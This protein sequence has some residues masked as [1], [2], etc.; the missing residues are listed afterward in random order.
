[1]MMSLM[2]RVEKRDVGG[3]VS[4]VKGRKFRIYGFGFMFLDFGV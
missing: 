3:D 4:Y 1:M 2:S